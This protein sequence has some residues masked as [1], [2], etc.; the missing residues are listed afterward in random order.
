MKLLAPEEALL[1]REEVSDPAS[2]P[3]T[4]FMQP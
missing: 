1:V 4:A 2:F 3:R